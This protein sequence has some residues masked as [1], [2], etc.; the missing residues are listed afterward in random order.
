MSAFFIPHLHSLFHVCIL[1][2]RTECDCDPTG[3]L[4]EG[5]CD[6][7][8]EPEFN[9]EAGRCRCKTF[10]T[11][12]R[13]DSCVAGYWNMQESNQDG[14]EGMGLT[15]HRC[16]KY[17]MSCDDKDVLAL[18]RN[19]FFYGTKQ[20][21]LLSVCCNLLKKHSMSCSEWLIINCHLLPRILWI[22]SCTH[23]TLLLFGKMRITVV[24]ATFQHARVTQGVLLRT[25][26]VTSTRA[27]VPASVTSP[28]RVVTSAM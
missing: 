7:M 4:Y 28:A 20:I 2:S 16:L 5:E 17:N 12:R 9:M 18:S 14:C 24:S 23:H 19:F 13:C 1:Y 21:C 15:S 26:G 11:G 3:A 10:V 8:T 6:R 27:T 25:S 22:L